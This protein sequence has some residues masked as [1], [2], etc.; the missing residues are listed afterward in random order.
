[1]R[2]VLLDGRPVKK[3]RQTPDGMVKVFLYDGDKLVVTGDEWKRRS[4]SRLYAAGV[5]RSSVTRTT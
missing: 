4:E 2:I 5:R 3:Q 1:M